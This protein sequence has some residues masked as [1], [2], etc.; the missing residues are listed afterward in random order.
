MFTDVGPRE[1][2]DKLLQAS[3]TGVNSRLQ[4]STLQLPWLIQ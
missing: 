3:C 1:Q 2:L 4:L